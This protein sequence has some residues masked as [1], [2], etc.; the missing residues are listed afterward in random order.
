MVRVFANA[1]AGRTD[2][3]VALFHVQLSAIVEAA[4]DENEAVE[5]VERIA[6]HLR[7]NVGAYW[8]RHLAGELVTRL[9]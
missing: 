5:H 9:K 3:F 7:A 1:N 4:A 6:R 8:K 2:V